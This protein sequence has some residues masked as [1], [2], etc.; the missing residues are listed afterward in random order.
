MAT[1]LPIRET[2]ANVWRDTVRVIRTYPVIWIVSLLVSSMITTMAGSETVKAITEN[3]ALFSVGWLLDAFLKLIPLLILLPAALLTHRLVVLGLR[4]SLVQVLSP[5]RRVRFYAGLEAVFV[6]ILI[7]PLGLFLKFMP[8]EGD[9]IAIVATLGFVATLATIFWLM[10][11]SAAVYPAIAM[12]ADVSGIQN[13]FRATRGRT[14]NIAA[15]ALLTTGP[16]ILAIIVLEVIGL[17]N[18]QE[19]LL[20]PWRILSDLLL[21]ASSLLW[22]VLMSNVYL[23][24]IVGDNNTG[25]QT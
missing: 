7:I 16:I 12:D 14:W 17:K 24:L 19:Q 1:Q 13:A 3:A 25:P 2:S 8:V 22:V 6:A 11:R 15:I 21:C 5:L 10:F 20:L 4:E 9:E 23:R 18:E